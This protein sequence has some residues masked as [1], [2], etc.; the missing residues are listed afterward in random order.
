MS[1]LRWHVASGDAQNSAGLDRIIAESFVKIADTKQENRI[2]M[3]RFDRIILLHQR[4]S[5]Y[6]FSITFQDKV[7]N[8]GV[9]PKNPAADDFAHAGPQ[10]CSTSCKYTKNP[11]QKDFKI[12]NIERILHSFIIHIIV[13]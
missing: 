10:D 13:Q 3:H 9:N 6:F 11:E 1:R 2:G 8:I 7:G 5:T 12:T 4:V